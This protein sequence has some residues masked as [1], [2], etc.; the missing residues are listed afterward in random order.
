MISLVLC[1]PFQSMF[2]EDFIWQLLLF[3]VLKY[4]LLYIWQKLMSMNLRGVIQIKGTCK[5]PT[6]LAF[7]SIIWPLWQLC[8]LQHWSRTEIQHFICELLLGMSTAGAQYPSSS[9][10]STGW[11]CTQHLSLQ[12]KHD[13]T[14]TF[15]GPCKSNFAYLPR[16]TLHGLCP[17]QARDMPRV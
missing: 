16:E 3:E 7:T 14:A 2:F 10:D 13:K 12:R 1:V 9:L 6:I 8:W 11:P 5:K 15:C 4:I 17:C